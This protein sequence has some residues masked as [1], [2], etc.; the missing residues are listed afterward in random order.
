M[1]LMP[2]IWGD[3]IDMEFTVRPWRSV[4]MRQDWEEDAELIIAI[5]TEK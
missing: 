4:S 1:T 5:H 3:S 2:K